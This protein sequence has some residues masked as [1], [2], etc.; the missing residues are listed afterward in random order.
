MRG[1]K[2]NSRQK[3]A[4]D[5]EKRFVS[6]EKSSAQLLQLAIVCLAIASFFTT[7]QGMKNYIFHDD[8]IAYVTSGAI[9]GI[10]LALSMSL[11]KFISNIWEKKA[12]KTGVKA[13]ITLVLLVL[14]AISLFC[15][16]WFSYVYIAET[17][18]KGSW[19]IESEL[20][21]QQTYRKELYKAS[22]YAKTYRTYLESELGQKILS[23]QTL[24]NQLPTQ[25]SDFSMDWEAERQRYVSDDTIASSYMAT[26][27]DQMENAFVTAPSQENRSLAAQAVEQA[28]TS[29][30]AALESDEAQ[31]VSIESRLQNY[32]S[33]ID[34]I[35][36]QIRNADAQT[37]IESLYALLSSYRGMQ[38]T[39]VNEQNRLQQEMAALRNV[40]GRLAIYAVDLGLSNSTSDISIKS[41]LIEMQTELFQD[42]PNDAHLLELAT[43]TFTSLRDSEAFSE[44]STDSNGSLSYSALLTQMNALVLNLNDYSDVKSIEK[45]LNTF[46]TEL[47]EA[48]SIS[49]TMQDKDVAA[50]TSSSDA[51]ASSAAADEAAADT[52]DTAVNDGEGA[53]QAPDETSQTDTDLA[54]AN[55]DNEEP[56]SSEARAG[57]INTG[58]T[59]AD[60]DISATAND[61]TWKKTWRGRLEKLKAQISALPTFEGSSADVSE[62][63]ETQQAILTEFDRTASCANLDNTT[64]R[65]INDHNALE[66]G[67]IY[68]TSPYRGLA[69]FALMLAFFLDLSGFVFGV[70]DLNA[71][72]PKGESSDTNAPREDT[73]KATEEA[74]G[75]AQNT[76]VQFNDFLWS[77]LETAHPYMVVTEQFR[78]E[79]GVYY[80]SA[81]ENGIHKE[82]KVCD[83][84]EYPEGVYVLDKITA[85]TGVRLK[86]YPQELIFANQLAG[87]DAQDGIL[88]N[89][90]LTYQE[91]SLLFKPDVSVSSTY[92]TRYIASIDEYVPVHC[93]DPKRGENLTQ[94]AMDLEKHPMKTRIVVIA[95]NPKGTRIVAIYLIINN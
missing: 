56:A 81:F 59:T 24:A 83:T 84:H 45:E 31:E 6:E 32:S 15:S 3:N 54:A 88:L 11:P 17:I 65:Y 5:I 39:A 13:L 58:A 20:L 80:Y 66:Q 12:F 91:G 95:L 9:Q 26:V 57:S 41:N 51:A 19:N 34:T 23:L 47:R 82:W 55:T 64:R 25:A 75:T 70:V 33:Q 21:V 72:E 50:S 85:N 78:H 67:T 87:V 30:A 42:N 53:N 92:Q 76:K 4:A 52:N 74:V 77:T 49:D 10:L 22:D 79:D 73:P 38:E 86:E 2:V 18:H 60:A 43:K 68:L 71:T 27:I 37:N 94:P 63:T 16:S 14:S 8:A 44:T 69:L 7:A 28:Q 48:D 1:I 61:A 46:I 29:V 90:T 93:Y 36:R 62:I 35:S 40:S 89:G